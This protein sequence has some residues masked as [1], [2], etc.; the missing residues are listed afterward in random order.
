MLRM[1]I[2]GDNVTKKIGFVSLG[3]NKNLCDTENMMGLLAESSFEITPS[4]DE[5]DIIV[6]NTCGFIES[7]QQE[8]IDTILEM[9]QYKKEKCKLLVVCGCLAQRFADEMI[10]RGIVDEIRREEGNLRYEYFIPMDDK[11]SV[12]LIDSWENQAAIDKHH[13]TPMM[14]Q[15]IE[16]RE[17]YDLHMKVERYVS[18]ELPDADKRFIKD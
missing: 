5:A 2:E 14:K 15:I 18:D 11:E 10:S 1:M 3:C 4:P 6:V 12:L 7:A 13:K 17:K 16:L 8:S 9:A